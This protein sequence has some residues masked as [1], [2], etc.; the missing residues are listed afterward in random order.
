MKERN[1]D[2]TNARLKEA[3]PPVGPGGDPGRD[4]W[5]DLLRRM[6]ET[7]QP[8]AAE[9]AWPK[10]GWLDWALLGGVVLLLAAF[11]ASI[12]VLLYYL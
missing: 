5:P 3:L 7:A 4:L 2:A 1:H 10:T 11:P 9:A 8:R 6:G 12:P